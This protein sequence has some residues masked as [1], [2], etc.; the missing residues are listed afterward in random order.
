M[1]SHVKGRLG[2]REDRYARSTYDRDTHDRNRSGRD[3]D[4]GR[5]RDTSRDR[6]RKSDYYRGHG[7]LRNRMIRAR[8]RDRENRHDRYEGKQRSMSPAETRKIHV[9]NKSNEI[10]RRRSNGEPSRTPKLTKHNYSIRGMISGL[11]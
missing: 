2:R 8:G 5:Y 9:R 7:D 11:N 3:R 6:D 4:I 1:T 10:I